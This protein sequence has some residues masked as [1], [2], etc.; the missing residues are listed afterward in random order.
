MPSTLLATFVNKINNYHLSIAIYYGLPNVKR[1]IRRTKENNNKNDTWADDIL[2]TSIASFALF[3]FLNDGLISTRF[4]L[5][6]IKNSHPLMCIRFYKHSNP[7]DLHISNAI[8]LVIG[9]IKF[10]YKNTLFLIHFW[11]SAIKTTTKLEVLK[12]HEK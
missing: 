11:T 2:L 10:T 12:L 6:D 1:Q 8:S 7:F 9:A 5:P 4:L 3:S